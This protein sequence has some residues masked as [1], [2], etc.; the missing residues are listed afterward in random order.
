MDY[1]HSYRNVRPWVDWNRCGQAAVATVLDYHGLDPYGLSRPLYDERDGRYHWDDGEIIDRI[2]E[3]FPPDHAFGL[4][5]TTPERIRDALASAGL[6]ACT[7]SSRGVREGL[8]IWEEVKSSA[9][10]GQPVIV[11]MDLGKL[12]GRPFTAHWGVVYGVR[13]ST[14]RLANTGMSR[15]PEELFLRAFRCRFMLPPFNHC[16]VFCRP[17]PLRTSALL[18]RYLLFRQGAVS[19]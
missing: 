13:H 4:F 10:A 11:I 6:E 18:D 1:L 17:H 2:K 19:R 9:A 16:A 7:A 14:V 3:E 5:G 15:V 8:R 12:G